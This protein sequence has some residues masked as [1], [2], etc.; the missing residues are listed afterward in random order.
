MQDK[1]TGLWWSKQQ[2]SGAWNAA[3]N[4]C[5][6]TLN[7]TTYAGNALAGYNG[8]TGWRLPTQKELMESYTHGIRSAARTNWITE[9]DM[10]NWFWSGSS[11]SDYTLGAWIV[12]LAYGFTYN[13]YKDSPNQVVCV[14]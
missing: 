8:Q 13:D 10:G 4:T 1:I 5:V 11:V 14:R 9:G 7:N 6:T 12:N 3:W 2:A